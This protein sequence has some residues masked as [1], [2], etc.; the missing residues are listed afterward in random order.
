M[1][2]YAHNNQPVHHLPYLFALLGDRNTTALMVRRIM[3][4]G[5]S[6]DGFIGDEDNGE[7][8]AWYVLG[9]LG[10]YSV[11]VGVTEDYVL[12]AMPL[13]P[14]V[15]LRDLD[16]TIEAA[17]ATEDT[18]LVGNVLWKSRPLNGES[19]PY[20]ILRQGGVLSFLLPG[21]KGLTDAAGLRG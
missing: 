6:T 7:M 15:R 9:A 12:G 13:F 4:L 18:P 5:Y 16:I 2:Q 17:G 8:G 3:S 1:G 20:S 14:R 10:L 11:A 21:D 19:V